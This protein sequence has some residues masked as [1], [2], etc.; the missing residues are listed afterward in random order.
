MRKTFS[1]V[2]ICFLLMTTLF[3]GCGGGKDQPVTDQ[4][5]AAE[6]TDKDAAEKEASVADIFARSEGIQSMTFDWVLT[7]TSGVISEGT[8]YVQ[9]GNIRMDVSSPEGEVMMIFNAS[10]NEAWMVNKTQNVAMKLGGADVEAES[11]NPMEPIDQAET[12]AYNVIGHEKYDGKNCTVME[13]NYDGSYAKIWVWDEYGFPL[14]Y[15]SKIEEQQVVYEYKNVNFDKIPDSVFE[16][17]A[18]VQ[19]MDLSSMSNFEGMPDMN[20]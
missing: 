1:L 10:T 13:M 8:Q 3:A 16:V 4:K 12:D 2:L 5:S 18:G 9:G 14:K 6:N 17:P 11:V 20:P 19:I 15:E 7:G